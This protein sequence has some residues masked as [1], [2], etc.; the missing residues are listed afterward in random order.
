FRTKGRR[1]RVNHAVAVTVTPGKLIGFEAVAKNEKD[2]TKALDALQSISFFDAAFAAWQTVSSAE[3]P[4]QMISTGKLFLERFPTNDIASYV[5]KR[6]AFAYQQLNDFENLVTHGDKTLELLPNDPDIRPMMA[7]A[8]AERGDNNRA[9]D[10]AQQGIEVIKAMEKPAEMSVSEWLIRSERS[11]SDSNYAQGLAY[12]KK[13]S[14][15]AG[16]G[17][18][19]MKRAVQYLSESTDSDPEF[20][21][22]YFRLGYAHTRLNEAE[23]A[24]DSYA[25]AVASD[26]I[27]SALAREQL[28]TILEFLKRDPLTIDQLVQEQRDYID[29]K[30]AER[31]ALAQQMEAEEELRLQQEMQQ[32][33]MDLQQQEGQ[34]KKS[35]Y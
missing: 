2:A 11:M 15:M 31:E 26:G 22:A 18:A 24:V 1:N 33:E 20:D 35:L 27:A 30:I 19:M 25:R 5:H 4:D 12:L 3:T 16:G 8:F 21:A 7:L 17:E 28:A 14:G 10:L 23:L 13:S 9:I 6:M 32:Q 34:P 29:Q